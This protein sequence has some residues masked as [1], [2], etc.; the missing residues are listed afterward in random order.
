V[1]KKGI[2]ITAVLL[3]LVLLTTAS[4]QANKV[5]YVLTESAQPSPSVTNV[6]TELGLSYDVIKNSQIPTTNWSNYSIL[7]VSEDSTHILSNRALIPFDSINSVS[8]GYR[9]AQQVW[10]S[11]IYSTSFSSNQYQMTVKNAS[12]FVFDDL[13]LTL[14]DLINVYPSQSSS[15]EIDELTLRSSSGLSYAAFGPSNRL[16]LVYS[17]RTITST[18]V[19][20]L[21]FGAPETSKWSPTSQQ[22]LKNSLTWLLQDVDQDGDGYGFSLDCND[23][24]PTIHP[25]ATEIPYD[26]IDQNCDSVDL[27]DIDQDGYCEQGLL[28]TSTF[29]QCPLETGLFGTDCNDNDSNTNPGSSDSALNCRN[30]APEILSI[31]YDSI[32]YENDEAILE[33]NAV[34]PENDQIVYSID[35][36]NFISNENILSWQTGFGDAAIYSF[37]VTVSDGTLSSSQEVDF[38][39]LKVHRSPVFNGSTQIELDED[40]SEFINLS[41]MFT[42]PDHNPLTFSIKEISSNSDVHLVQD[43]DSAEISAQNNFNGPAGFVIF[44]ASDGIQSTDSEKIYINVLPIN[45]A[46]EF[47]MNILPINLT[48]DTDIS[49]ALNLNDYF[50]DIDSELQFSVTGNSEIETSINNFGAVSFHLPKDYFGSEVM[51]FQATDGEFTLDSN[52]VT[53]NVREVRDPPVF[54]ELNCTASIIEHQE[55]QCALSATDVE[56]DSF[57]FSVA[58][59]NYLDCEVDGDI[60]IY[61]SQPDHFGPASCELEVKDIDGSDFKNLSVYIQ[62]VNDP[63]RFVNITPNSTTIRALEGTNKA[64][65]V[66]AFDSDSRVKI[67]WN[68]NGIQQKVESSDKSQFIIKNGTGVYI[69]EAVAS[70]SEYTASQIWTAIFGPST[71]M[72]C[73][74]VGG[75]SCSTSETC[76]GSSIEVKDTDLCCLTQCIPSFSGVNSCDKLGG[77]LTVKIQSINDNEKITIGDEVRVGVEIKNSLPDDDS[78]NVN[79]YLYNIRDEIAEESIIGDADVEAGRTSTIRLDLPIPEDLDETDNYAIYAQVEGTEC[80]WNYLPITLTRPEKKV[81]ISKIDMPAT[82]NCGDAVKAKVTVEN[83]GNDGQDVNLSLTNNAI[84]LN[85]KPES[86]SIDEFNGEEYEITK[87]V[88]FEVPQNIKSGNYDLRADLVYN[89]ARQ[90]ATQKLE[91]TCSPLVLEDTASVPN[92]EETNSQEKISLTNF[93]GSKSQTIGENKPNMFVLASVLLADLLLIS[94]VGI[95]H[96]ADVKRRNRTKQTLTSI[97]RKVQPKRLR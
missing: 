82:A 71:D 66:D 6:L 28:I 68:L 78:Y 64:F 63:P 11:A 67:S 73:S 19:K 8:F 30:D 54:S 85:Y 51:V 34:D 88:T 43:E 27:I 61:K 52:A 58:K 12:S 7:I 46:P 25:D 38:E 62:N 59:E 48:E 5:A 86:F 47:I 72:T 40:S 33:I 31:N 9:T 96:L 65:G 93:T 50:K 56:G 95:L 13:S 77:N 81:I 44:T 94:T 57:K 15:G 75:F 14:N 39:I 18:P 20:S 22:I 89:G 87:E 4:A 90:S 69:L 35:S 53:I 29:L 10:G 80:N 76:K 21:F 17:L 49:N 79:V 60:L 41:E 1:N 42:S 97:K 83:I 3:S 84:K 2:L 16:S 92:L 74:E 70:D 26:G 24:N 23:N 55:Y 36:P 45:D 91:V 37:N 32:Y